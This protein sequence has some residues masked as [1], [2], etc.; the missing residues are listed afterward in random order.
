[1]VLLL[2][3]FFARQ[4]TQGRPHG[5]P[6]AGAAQTA[7]VV[8]RTQDTIPTMLTEQFQRGAL[9]SVVSRPDFADRF[10]AKMLTPARRI[11]YARLNHELIDGKQSP[12]WQRPGEGRF[13]V[14]LPEG[15]ALTVLVDRSEMLDAD[16]FTSEGHL[17][18]QPASRVIVSYHRGG[19]LTASILAATLP[20]TAS[21]GDT[22]LHNFALRATGTD[23]AQFYEVD[24]SLIPPCGGGVEPVRDG[25]ALAVL[26]LRQ[27]AAQAGDIGA[28][29]PPVVASAVA[30]DSTP[31]VTVDLMMLYTQGVDAAL[32][33]ATA[34]ARAAAVQ[35]QFDNTVALVNS[36]FAR[37]LIT[38]RVRL[39]KV[40]MVNLPGDEGTASMSGWQSTALTAL[41]QT[42]DGVMDEIHPLRDQVGADLVC[43]AVNRPDSGCSGIGYVLQQPTQVASDKIGNDLYG[44][45]VVGYGLITSNS[46]VSHELGHNFGCQHD[47]ENAGGAVGAYSYSYGY[48]FYG[49]NGA[50][51]RTIM[52]YAPGVRLGYFSNPNVTATEPGVGVLVGVP[53]GQP[54]EA[55]NALTMEKDAFEVAGFRLQQQAAASAGTLISVSTRAYVGTGDQQLIG[56]FSVAGSESKQMLLRAVGAGLAQYGV[57]G[58]LPNP[59]LMIVPM[60]GTSVPA[61]LVLANDD[62]TNQLNPAAVTTAAAAVY[63][64][65]LVNYPLDSALLVTLP[66]GSYSAIVEGV[67]GTTG[68][69]LIEAYEVN[70]P[71]DTK[72]VSL[73]TRGY[74]DIG[75]EM[76]AGFDVQGNPGETKRILIRV[77]GPNLAQYGVTGAMPDP[78]LELHAADSTILIAN[79]DWSAGDT[80]VVNGISDDFTPVVASYSEKAIAATGLAPKNR[81][82]PAVLVDLLPGAYT[83]VVKPFEKLNPTPP[84]TPQIAQ[85]GVALVEVFEI[86]P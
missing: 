72:I 58:V 31:H 32:P 78:C 27:A 56:G 65:S 25:D 62:W 19:Q 43:L 16:R 49:Q 85:P 70:R 48:R 84:T 24:E 13:T 73:S 44:F 1:L 36:D 54:G 35:T 41:R 68:V 60:P 76:I 51:Y 47:R 11:Y 64:F 67:G 75:R 39:V 2:V 8:S 7:A 15:G 17:D 57:P 66:P 81:L 69:A 28:A 61:G 33:G 40:A 46:V 83:V 37:S 79:D 12:F 80:T 55:C 34:T 45:T 30:T 82:E 22:R 26:A 18:G 23:V 14:P 4:A 21:S 6:A 53:A 52:A 59:K 50:Q 63:D 29:A 5:Q 86:K 9:L 42:N 10:E 3:T 38:A 71:G 20:S 74:A 77:Q